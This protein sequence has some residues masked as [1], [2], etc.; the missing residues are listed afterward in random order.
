LTA[1][2][3]HS[4]EETNRERIKLSLKPLAPEPPTSEAAPSVLDEEQQAFQNF[5][6]LREKQAKA[7]EE[8]DIKCRVQKIRDKVKLHE[9]LSGPTLGNTNE[10]EELKSWVKKSK[11]QERALPVNHE[12]EFESR[13]QMFQQYTSDQLDELMVAHDFADIEQGEDMILTIKD[14]DVL[15]EEGDELVS[16]VLAEKERLKENLDNKVKRPKYDP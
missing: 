15:A 10:E 5:K 13:D 1:N 4:L 12:Q 16:T 2:D 3:L 11:K 6:R 9:R 8:T 14:K 7:A